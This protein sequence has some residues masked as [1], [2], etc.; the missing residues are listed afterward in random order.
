MDATNTG[1]RPGRM[2]QALSEAGPSSRRD[3]YDH[4]IN[5][6]CGVG[7]MAELKMA[8]THNMHVHI[9]FVFNQPS[10]FAGCAYREHPTQKQPVLGD[11]AFGAPIHPQPL[12]TL[13]SLP[14]KSSLA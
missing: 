3:G 9:P 10:S 4:T 11:G 13:A 14:T 12:E 6:G 2:R 5:D 1:M 7:G 8:E